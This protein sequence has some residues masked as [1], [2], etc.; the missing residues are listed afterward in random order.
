MKNSSYF[1]AVLLGSSLSCRQQDPQP[2]QTI[3]GTYQATYYDYSATPPTA[4]PINGHTIT[5]QIAYVSAD[6][7]RVTITPTSTGAALPTDIYSPT[8]ALSYSKAYVK[9]VVSGSSTAYYVYLVTPPKNSNILNDVL[10]LYGGKSI[11]DYIFTPA[12]TPTRSTII[13][14]DKP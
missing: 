9:K 2:T 5:L 6:T 1:I 3:E 4:Y 14:F 12:Q 13:R 11:A 7:A 8:Q 10:L